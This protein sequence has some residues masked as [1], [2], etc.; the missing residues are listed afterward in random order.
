[1]KPILIL[2]A[3]LLPAL[4]QTDG[5]LK[6]EAAD[7]RVS[8]PSITQFSRGNVRNSRYEIRNA[9]IVDMIR[10][11]YGFDPDH[12]I[13]G[14]QWLEMDRFD[15][16]ALMPEKTT[17]DDRKTML[18]NLLADRFKLVAHKDTRP[19][20]AYSLIAGK[21]P[22]LKEADGDGDSGCKPQASS[23]GSGPG[24]IRLFGMTSSGG[25]AQTLTLGADGSLQYVCRNMTMKSFA[26]NLHS[27]MGVNIGNNYPILDETGL[28]GRW[29][30]DFHTNLAIMTP[31]GSMNAPPT[32]FEILDKQLGLKLVDKPK[33]APVIVVESVNRKPE[34]NPPGTAEALPP[35]TAPTE[36]DVASIKQVEMHPGMVRRTQNRP[37]AF[38]LEGMPMSYLLSRAFNVNARDAIVNMP[39]WADT[40]LFDVMAKAAV[41]GGGALDN[42]TAAPMLLALLKDRFKLA[43]HTEE[44][45]VSAYALTAGGKSKLKPSDPSARTHCQNTYSPPGT[46]PG[47]RLLTCKNISVEEFATQ[48]RG[49]SQ[50]LS[51]PVTDLTEIQGRF[52]ITVNFNQNAGRMMPNMAMAVRAGEGGGDNPVPVASDATPGYTFFEAVE[53]ELGLKLV[54]HKRN[55]QVFVIDHIEQKPTDN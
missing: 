33:P 50:E 39:A 26:E 27:M 4:A 23:G 5:P 25:A 54:P 10:M 12:T 44:R 40:T 52:D 51:W 47:T 28:E 37:G 48:L 20:P 6:F 41:E 46:P 16:T 15:V 11:A 43:Y 22:N 8:P 35:I 14:P 17:P 49:M 29:N 55:E 45:Q 42:D 2:A 21:K 38:S 9:S 31:T 30:F 32:I 53:K 24:T 18:Q 19:M 7:V 36:F 1:M 3:A 13:G 34:A